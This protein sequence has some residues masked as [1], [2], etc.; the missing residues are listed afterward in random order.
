MNGGFPDGFLWGAAT[1]AH[2]VEGNNVNCDTWA[3]ENAEGSPY[4]ERSGDGIDHYRLYREDIA[5]M[6]SLGLKAYRFS[7]E[8]ARVEPEAGH[9]SRSA[10]EHYRD[11]LIACREHG[12]TPIVTMHHFTSPRWLMRFGGWSDPATADRFAAY[13]EKV[14]SELGD[15]IP[16]AL[17]MNEVDLPVMLREL[18]A[19]M[20]HLPPV[21]I[22][23]KS[24]TAPGWREEAA[25]LCGTTADR[26][27]P[28]LNASDE[29]SIAI[30]KDAH[31]KARTA[32]KR[33]RPDIRVGLTLALPDVQAL[34]GGEEIADRVWQG[35][36]RQFIDV[37]ADDDL[38]GVQNYTREVYGPDGAVPPDEGAE[39]TQMG[40]E[41][42]PEALSRVV[43]RVARDL[44]GVP[45]L[46]TEHGVATDDDSR[47]VEFIR[48]GLQALRECL[49]E[50]IDVKG[51]M[52]WSAFD[53]FEWSFG[54]SKRFGI[55]GVDRSTMERR[56]K[57]SACYLGAIAQSDGERI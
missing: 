40:Y 31:V 45:I 23:A 50:G 36:F 18:F 48:R 43:R 14:V 51:Y 24:W 47:R 30:I 7:V 10:L 17:T 41:Y 35:Y 16:Y 27:F 49:T 9:Y 25:R 38:V 6:A 8:W 11:V 1:A 53:N 22:E 13:C 29:A 19:R 54:Y 55:I 12:L 15:L 3:E 44:P 33:A 4:A 20:G 56:A 46:V 34:P 39:L 57:E 42:D 32:M 37:M 28:F 52:Y 21:G 5:L 2:Q 26:Y